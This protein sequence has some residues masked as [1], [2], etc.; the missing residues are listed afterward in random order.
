MAN[1]SFLI[2]QGQNFMHLNKIDLQRDND[3]K[4]KLVKCAKSRLGKA[5]YIEASLHPNPRLQ[6]TPIGI[7]N[8]QSWILQELE[9]YWKRFNNDKIYI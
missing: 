6:D 9:K 8:I 3:E 7:E 4:E 5:V 2:F 1:Y